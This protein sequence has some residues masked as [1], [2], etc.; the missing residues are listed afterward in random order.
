MHVI[1]QCPHRDSAAP[2]SLGMAELAAFLG[3]LDAEGLTPVGTETQAQIDDPATSTEEDGPLAREVEE[4]FRALDD[5]DNAAAADLCA[6]ASAKL[7]NAR[8]D[9]D[10]NALF[11][12]A[13]EGNLEVT[14]V[15]LSR[16]DFLG[17]NE[18]NCI[19]STALHLAAGND[20]TDICRAILE[21][22]RFLEGVNVINNNGQSPLDFA[23]EFGSGAAES[24]LREAGGQTARGS[25]R[26]EL[27][28]HFRRLGNRSTVSTALPPE[29]LDGADIDLMMEMDSLD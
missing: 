4:L 29:G 25:Q 3:N 21:C 13:A 7:I 24:I 18:R 23:L 6:H 9:L 19:G 8:D 14:H 20:Q 26:G 5:P 28:S 11:V 1:L 12:A 2:I 10:R 22:P 17:V 15:L 27:P 16:E